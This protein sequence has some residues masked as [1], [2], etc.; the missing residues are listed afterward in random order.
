MREAI[1]VLRA[2]RWRVMVLSAVL[3]VPCFWQR[4]IQAG[5][6][7][8]HVYNAWL[9]QLI[10]R[11]QAPGLYLAH[12]W[13][14][15]LVDVGLLR[16]GSAFGFVAA[17]R[18]VASACVLM[19]FWGAFALIASLTGRL[20]WVLA[21]G[22]AMIAY[23]WTFSMGFLNFYLSLGLGLAATALVLSS[24]RADWVAAAALGALALLAHPMGFLCVVG[25]AVYLRFAGLLRGW[26]RWL[27]PVAGLGAVFLARQYALRHE[28]DF[29]GTSFFYRMNGADQLVLYG[30]RYIWL[31]YG[32]FLFGCVCFLTG[33]WRE[34]PRM[35]VKGSFRAPL[36]VWVLLLFAAAVVPE[37]F[38]MPQ[39]A[40]VVAFVISRVTLVSAIMGLA[41]LATVRPRRW[42]LLGLL[43]CASRYFTW[44][45]HDTATLNGMEEQAEALVKDLPYGRRVTE[46]IW[47]PDDSRIG[48]IN[49]IVDRA[50]IGRCFT[51]SNYEPSS[52]QFRVR[53][54]EGS[55]IVTDVPELTEQMESGEYAVQAK[56]LPMTEIF[57]CDE[58]D[59]TKLCSRELS[60]GEPNG[61]VGY[62]PPKD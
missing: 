5:D 59:L 10:E 38:V 37:V 61:R 60:A 24:R 40:G 49:H 15:I 50:C 31:A 35:K 8:S 1:W 9:A 27:L 11:G 3:L 42:H 32:V 2:H 29:W 4:R 53:V 22:L 19:F 57:Q 43:V 26:L 41:V 28:P 54:R 20:P 55:P 58:K 39:Y 46:T 36:E 52:G 56:D 7:A 34:W 6:L 44:M 33:A 62:H 21:P 30:D 25:L 14:N 23:G 47:A 17:E 45:Y 13:N 16:L 51:Y 12:Q 18:I 48:F